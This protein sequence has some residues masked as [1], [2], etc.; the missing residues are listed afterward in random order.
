MERLIVEKS[1]AKRI[2]ERRVVECAR[3]LIAAHDKSHDA[4]QHPPRG[5]DGRKYAMN[6]GELNDLREAVRTVDSFN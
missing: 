5:F 3:A 2:A 6:Y 1:E 4:I